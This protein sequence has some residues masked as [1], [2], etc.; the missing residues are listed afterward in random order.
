MSEEQQQEETHGQEE[1]TRTFSEEIEVAGNELVERIKELVQEGNIRRLII[2]N[3][4]GKS[5]IEIP[6]TGAVLVGGMTALALP[7]IAALGGRA[8]FVARVKIE[9]VRDEKVKNDDVEMDDAPTVRL[10]KPEDDE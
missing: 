10:Q 8:A 3:S 6:L 4:E 7:M 9:I 1:T 5:L 2:R